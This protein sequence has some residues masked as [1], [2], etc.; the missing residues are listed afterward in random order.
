MYSDMGTTHLKY[1]NWMKSNKPTDKKFKSMLKGEVAGAVNDARVKYFKR[2]MDHACDN[3]VKS[4]G[5]SDAALEHSIFLQVSATDDG[6][7]Q[8][9]KEEYCNKQKETATASL[10][11]A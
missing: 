5:T 1:T 9:D 6:L 11:A 10:E 3:N 4:K 7:S 8:E 2:L